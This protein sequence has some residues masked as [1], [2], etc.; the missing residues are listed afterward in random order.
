MKGNERIFK[1]CIFVC[2]ILYGLIFNVRNVV[3]FGVFLFLSVFIYI[4]YLLD[5]DKLSI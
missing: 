5:I 1:N 4:V 3:Y 2:K